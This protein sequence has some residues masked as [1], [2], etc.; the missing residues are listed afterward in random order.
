[1]KL[2]NKEEDFEKNLNNYCYIDKKTLEFE[3]PEEWAINYCK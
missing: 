1:L 2:K 3:R